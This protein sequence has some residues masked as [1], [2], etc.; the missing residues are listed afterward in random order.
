MRE[1]GRYQLRYVRV[2]RLAEMCTTCHGAPDTIPPAVREAVARRYPDDR[3][4]GFSPGDLR[5][6]VSVRV[7]VGK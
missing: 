2:V 3:A 1:G 6:V 7:P 5:G 4:T